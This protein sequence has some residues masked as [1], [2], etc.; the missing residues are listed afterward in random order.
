VT[1]CGE[2]SE[3]VEQWQNAWRQIALA[4]TKQPSH[5]R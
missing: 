1:T 3:H 5:A 4:N 2:P